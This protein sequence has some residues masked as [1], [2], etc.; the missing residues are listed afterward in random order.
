[1]II[2]CDSFCGMGYIYLQPQTYNLEKENSIIRCVEKS[3]LQIPLIADNEKGHLLDEMRLSVKT[4]REAVN[5]GEIDEEYKNDLDKNGYIVGIELNLTKDTFDNRIRNGAYKLYQTKWKE[6]S[7]H[8]ATVDFDDSVFDPKNI[9]YPL[10]KKNDAF[11]VVELTSDYNI[12]LIKALITSR[13]DL[14]PIEYLLTPHFILN[15]YT[16]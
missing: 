11:L 15:E 14:Y 8:I 4:Y 7:Y 1:V 10:S 2:T 12:G 5:S 13:D 3:S 9:I 16:S 6:T